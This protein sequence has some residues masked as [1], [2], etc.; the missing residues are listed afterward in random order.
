VAAHAVA[1]VVLAEA[2]AAF[3]HDARFRERLPAILLADSLGPLRETVRFA[4]AAA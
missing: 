1:S 3:E 2:C 4:L